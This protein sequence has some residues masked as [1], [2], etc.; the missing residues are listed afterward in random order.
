MTVG[1]VVV[2]DRLQETRK[3]IQRMEQ[4]GLLLRFLIKPKVKYVRSITTCVSADRPGLQVDDGVLHC[5]LVVFAHVL[6]HAQVVGAYVF[7][8]A[9]VGHRAELQG[10]V[11][12]LRMLELAK[13]KGGEGERPGGAAA[14]AA[15]C[16]P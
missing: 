9:A 4:N 2:Y 10:R 14:S 3:S 13:A 6:V 1:V 5:L 7:L 8:R 16:L 15:V 12:L 11:L